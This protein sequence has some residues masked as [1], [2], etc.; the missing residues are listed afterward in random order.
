[1]KVLLVSIAIGEKYILEYERLF[2]KSHEEYAKKCGYDYKLVT[3]LLDNTYKNHKISLYFQK[4]LV[5]SQDWSAEYDYIIYIDCDILIN[6]RNAPPI[7]TSCNFGNSIGI[8]DEYAQPTPEKRLEIQRKMDWEK[9]A[10][11]YYSLCGFN[12]VTDNVLNSGVLVFQ[13]SKHRQILDM[14]YEIYLPQ[15]LN[16]SRMHFEQ[17]CL[18]YELQISKEYILLPNSFNAIWALYKIAGHKDL[19]NFYDT[20][21]F[22]HF[23]GNT[24]FDK[25]PNIIL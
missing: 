6:T 2:K 4:M 12:I 14:I 9:S 24:D 19:Q 8:V 23:A 18:G 13:P 17:T 16:N 21:F 3:E 15:G 25:I 10:T 1:M 5:C 7:H 11:D 22:I 20:N